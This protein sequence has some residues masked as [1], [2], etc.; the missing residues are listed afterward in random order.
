[1]HGWS[2]YQTEKLAMVPYMPGTPVYNDNIYPYLYA[3]TR[4][5]GKL[6][7][8]FQEDG[9][10][11]G[12]FVDFFER[13]KTMQVLCH[14]E[15][16]KDLKPVGYSWVGAPSGVDGARGVICGFCFFREAKRTARD[17]G[18]LGI[19]YWFEDLRITILHGLILEHNTPAIN[20]S[21]RLGFKEVAYAPK[22]KYVD[23]RLVGVRLVQ[24]EAD[25]F[26]PGFEKWF[27]LQNAV[28]ITA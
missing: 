6:P 14:V 17:L 25:D 18:R 15:P 28:S 24:L 9:F 13:L 27:S 7:L 23:G 22:W 8:V 16:N 21:K 20:Y 5:E 4:D 1:M 19:A 2:W 12:K 11:L 10:N 3:K 26:M